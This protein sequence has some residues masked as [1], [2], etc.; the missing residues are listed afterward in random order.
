MAFLSILTLPDSPHLRIVASAEPVAIPQPVMP[1]G[2][3]G[4]RGQLVVFQREV[5]EAEP[6]LADLHAALASSQVAPA[7]DVFDCPVGLAIRAIEAAAQRRW[8]PNRAWCPDCQRS[9]VAP[10]SAAQRM[11]LACPQCHNPLLNPRWD[12]A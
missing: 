8:P 5:P 7:D 6:L 1:D 12:S 9:F 10:Y 3:F 2:T 11:Y 4:E